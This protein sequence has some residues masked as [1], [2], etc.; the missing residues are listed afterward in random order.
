MEHLQDSGR[1]LHQL[2]QGYSDFQQ[3]L[4]SEDWTLSAAPSLSAFSQPLRAYSLYLKKL[5]P[6]CQLR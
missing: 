3:G 2:K 4:E 1:Q 5:Q 6:Y